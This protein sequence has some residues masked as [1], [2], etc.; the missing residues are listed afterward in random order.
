MGAVETLFV[1][2][3]DSAIHPGKNLSSGKRFCPFEQPRPGPGW[4][5]LD[6]TIDQINCSP[7]D[8]YYEKQLLLNWVAGGFKF[9][10][11]ILFWVLLPEFSNLD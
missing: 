11:F 4:S 6:N 3:L 10:D 5:K 7:E 1:Q 8:N 9:A 2:I